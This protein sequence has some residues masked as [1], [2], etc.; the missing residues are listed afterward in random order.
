MVLLIVKRWFDNASHGDRRARHLH[1]EKTDEFS[2]LYICVR[3]RRIAEFWNA[4]EPGSIMTATPG[5]AVADGV[6]RDGGLLA[7]P[8]R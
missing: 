7:Y 4:T 3:K 6:Y 8:T 2:T 1:P 5:W